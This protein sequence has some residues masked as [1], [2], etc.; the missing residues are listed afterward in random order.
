MNPG[1]EVVSGSRC[2]KA[3]GHFTWGRFLPML[4][5]WFP[6]IAGLTPNPITAHLFMNSETMGPFPPGSACSASQLNE[7]F[8][9]DGAANCPSLLPSTLRNTLRLGGCQAMPSGGILDARTWI[10]CR[11]SSGKRFRTLGMQGLIRVEASALTPTSALFLRT[12]LGSFSPMCS[13]SCQM[14]IPSGP[15]SEAACH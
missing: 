6:L 7:L 3:T 8:G 15:S 1:F 2:P 10:T 14:P 12:R 9:R 11:F 5:E 13:P 4:V